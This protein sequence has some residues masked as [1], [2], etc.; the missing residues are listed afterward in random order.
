MSTAGIILKGTERLL[1]LQERDRCEGSLIEFSQYVWPVVEPAIPFV[2]GWVLEAIAE[3][4]EAV[5][6]GQIRRLL[7]NVPP[8]F[9][10]SLMTDVFFP[11]WLWGPLNRPHMRFLCAAYSE[12][13]TVRDNMRCRS[14]IVS[15]RYQALWKNRF[16]VSTDQFTKIKFA[17]DKT[18][19]KLA[20]SVGGIGTGERADIVIVD[21]P[22]NPMEMES[23]AIRETTKMWFTEILPDR[24]NNQALSSIIVIQQRT[25]Q[26]DVSGIALERE[27]GYT[28]LMIPMRHDRTR[29][30]TTVIG[31][32]ETGEEVTWTDPR[33]E[34][35]ELAWLERFPPKVCDELERDKAPYAWAG[36]Y[37]QLP[38][39]RGGSI[40][41]ND[42]WQVWTDR[43][44]PNLEYIVASL[45]SAYT[46]K[47]AN[48]PSALTIWG[49]FRE[50]N[51]V[52]E[53]SDILW[54]PRRGQ[55]LAP[56]DGRPKIILMWAWED[57]LALDELVERV[58]GC[59]IKGAKS[60]WGDPSFAVDRLLIESK[61]SGI[62][63]YQEMLRLVRGRGNLGV[64]LFDPK[65]YGDK[66]ARLHGVQHIFA[67][68][69]VYA[70]VDPD[71][72]NDKK[73]ASMVIDQ[74]AI[75]PNGARDDLVDSTSMALRWLR[76][77]GFA[78]RREENALAAEEEMRY[79]SP[80]SALPLYQV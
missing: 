34:E 61:A 62:S 20:T 73:Y 10:K 44:F 58:V 80:S 41:K 64:E 11:A 45:D 55:V 66:S 16:R 3:H 67:D 27:M 33:E 48:D 25:H 28:H 22:N 23:E 68:G 42:Y 50:Q 54:Q 60:R 26:E 75:F 18:G 4:L 70:P 17:N 24:L 12:H 65:R 6:Y 13:L 14:I 71:T 2:R 9:T 57:W 7:I 49:V 32:D 36:Q 35:G 8:G 63:V 15:D 79:V 1:A 39:P 59:C 29:H 37:Q 43:V 52:V 56:V 40:I 21:D 30:C 77:M 5:A 74:C 72:G 46:E 69:M 47:E 78:L 51:E 19:W 53:S 76:D 38:G 31:I